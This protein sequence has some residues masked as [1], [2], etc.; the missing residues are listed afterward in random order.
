[1]PRAD[2]AAAL[3][4]TTVACAAGAPASVAAQS[5][6][7]VA[8]WSALVGTPVGALPPLFTPTVAGIPLHSAQ[9]A[10]RYGHMG[11]GADLASLDDFA[12]TAILPAGMGATV[13]LTG[14]VVHASCDGCA[15]HLI[16][17][18]SADL[19]LYSSPLG[20]SSD[21]GR[22]SVALN[23]EFGYGHPRDATLLAGA[24]GLPVALVL[25]SS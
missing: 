17:S 8:A 10:L 11:G 25:G 9:L 22:L 5:E 6:G 1:M 3:L 15:N 21:A 16:L 12:A 14:G 24:V 19:S 18:M 7:D 2:L 4:I 23:G 20:P 13:S